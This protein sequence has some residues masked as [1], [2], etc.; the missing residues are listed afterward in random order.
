MLRNVLLSALL[1]CF[2][3]GV[4]LTLALGGCGKKK[5]GL[6]ESGGNKTVCPVPAKAGEASEKIGD[7]AGRVGRLEEEATVTARVYYA[8][9]GETDPGQVR[10]LPGTWL[11]PG[12]V[13]V[14]PEKVNTEKTEPDART[15]PEPDGG[16]K[17]GGR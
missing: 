8:D 7:D 11:V 5:A 17:H 15:E 4:A 14:A 3:F 10:V 6:K 12:P 13:F 2:V 1:T 9:G 16:A